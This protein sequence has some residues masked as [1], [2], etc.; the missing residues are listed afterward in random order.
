M[1]DEMQNSFFLVSS[2]R[3]VPC[4]GIECPCFAGALDTAQS[5][6]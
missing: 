2:G 5:V 6:P 4:R 1:P 3:L